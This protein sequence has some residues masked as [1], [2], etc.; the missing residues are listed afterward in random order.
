[1]GCAFSAGRID[2]RT[3]IGSQ[4]FRPARRDFSAERF[5]GSEE[6]VAAL[7][8]GEDDFQV[9]VDLPQHGAKVWLDRR[10]VPPDWDNE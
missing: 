2:G 7:I 4:D 5:E 9:G 10:E 6:R 1:V 8:D 3:V